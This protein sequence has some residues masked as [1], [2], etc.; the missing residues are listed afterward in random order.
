MFVC[1]Y[2]D[3]GQCTRRA[4]R[5]GVA[6]AKRDLFLHSVL[7]VCGK[8]GGQGSDCQMNSQYTK[9]NRLCAANVLVSW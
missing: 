3:G 8:L 9:N 6:G 5:K 1:S 7:R 4:T 2:V